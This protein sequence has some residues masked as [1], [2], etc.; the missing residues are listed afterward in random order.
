MIIL[1]E[2]K[3]IKKN[4]SLETLFKRK[5]LDTVDRENEAPYRGGG[6]VLI[7]LS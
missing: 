5:L 4:G 7:I 1:Q 3:R 6:E 2:N